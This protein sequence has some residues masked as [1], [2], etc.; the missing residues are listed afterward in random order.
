MAGPRG[1]GFQKLTKESLKTLPKLIGYLFKFYKVQM[2][3]L[4]PKK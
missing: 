2:L 4:P 1:R 3:I